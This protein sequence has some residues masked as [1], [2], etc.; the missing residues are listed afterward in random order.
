MAD[1][2]SLTESVLQRGAALLE[3]MASNSPGEQELLGGASVWLH[4][5][6]AGPPYPRQLVG[7]L[8]LAVRTQVDVRKELMQRC[9]CGWRCCGC[10]VPSPC[11]VLCHPSQRLLPAWLMDMC[12]TVAKK[13][14]SEAARGVLMVHFC[15]PHKGLL[16][17]PLFL[18]FQSYSVASYVTSCCL[19]NT[20]SWFGMGGR[21]FAQ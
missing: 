3:C 7:S 20:A 6:T 1:H 13:P 19:C 10:P 15:I 17:E 11:S 5:G 16:W 4:V 12:T 9:I 8:L 18:Y 14:L 2:Q 21:G